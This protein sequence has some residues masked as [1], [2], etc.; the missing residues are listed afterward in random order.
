MINSPVARVRSPQSHLFP[1]RGNTVTMLP[2]TETYRPKSLKDVVGNP[3]AIAE[4][5]KWALA[6][7]EGKPDKRAVIL[8]GDPGTGKTSAALALAADMGWAVVEMNASDKRNAEE[9]R[10]IALRAAV[11]QTFSET[12]E[13]LSTFAGG[14]KLVVLDEADNLFGREDSGGI[15]A[16]VD[17]MRQTRQPIVLLANDVYELTRRSA[18]FKALCRI[19]K[20]QPIHSSS[21]K[22]VLR[23]IAR[24]EGVAIPDEVVNYIAEHCEGDLRSAINDLELVARGELEVGLRAVDTIGSRDRRSSVFAA[25][26]EIFRSGEARRARTAAENLDESPEDLILWVDENLPIEYR[27][28]EDLA[29]GFTALSRADEYLSRVRRRQQYRLWSYASDMMTSGVAVARRGRFAGGR[30]QFPM[31]LLRQSRTRG[32]RNVR[33]SLASKLARFLHT[34]RAIALGEVLPAIR[35]LFEADSDFRFNVTFELGLDEKEVAFLLD[36]KEDSHSVRHLVERVA[37][38]RGAQELPEES[39]LGAE[40]GDDGQ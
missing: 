14:R 4:L 7:Q 35:F 15:G 19:I 20:F 9:I 22:A 3:S 17:T 27:H 10:K 26:E 8:H 38:R 16:I 36:E 12:G 37:K 29:R 33:A 30:L 13:F 34:S 23:A 1:A 32:I 25:L 6:W 40:A 31:W 24:T 21:V 28:P 39:R 2:W 5:E 11:A 18:A